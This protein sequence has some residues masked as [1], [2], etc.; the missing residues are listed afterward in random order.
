[1]CGHGVVNKAEENKGTK[2]GMRKRK[3]R[4]FRP[5]LFYENTE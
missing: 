1:M 2:D 3:S 4:I 5:R